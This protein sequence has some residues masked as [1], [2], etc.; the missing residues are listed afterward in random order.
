MALLYLLSGEV[1]HQMQGSLLI[2][3][4]RI[5]DPAHNV[6]IIGDILIHDGIISQVATEINDKGIADLQVV[7]AAGL[8]VV[9]GLIDMHVHLREPGLEAKET[10]ETGTRAAARGGFTSVACM[11]NTRPVVDNQAVVEF[12]KARAGQTG[13]VNV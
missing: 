10:I 9:P 5:I 7:E 13:L 6:D 8:L 4:G 2:K 3:G 1:A 12:I 11:P